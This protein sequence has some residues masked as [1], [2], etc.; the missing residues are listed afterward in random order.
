VEAADAALQPRLLVVDRHD[1]L[2]VH[3]ESVGERRRS[4]VGDG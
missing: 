2:D 4:P 3:A 1:D